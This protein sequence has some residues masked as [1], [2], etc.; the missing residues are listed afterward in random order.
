MKKREEGRECVVGRER[1]RER[2]RETDR[3]RESKL[4]SKE[5]LMGFFAACTTIH[6]CGYSF[7]DR[8]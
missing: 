5:V 7:S 8:G 6:T 1:K 3:E 2:E 4:A